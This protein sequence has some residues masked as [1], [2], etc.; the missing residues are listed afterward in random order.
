MPGT[1]AARGPGPW[2]GLETLLAQA[3]LH[4]DSSVANAIFVRTVDSGGSIGGLSQTPG[5]VMFFAEW[6][7][8]DDDVPAHVVGHE[9][10][11]NL[12][13]GHE[14]YG[15]TQDPAN[16]MYGDPPMTIDDIY[17]DGAQ[18]SHLSEE[19]IERVF[20]SPLVVPLDEG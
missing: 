13:L 20:E 10:G 2:P 6:V 5:T 18:M 14:D 1:L 3:P 9:P 4:G 11:H 19:Q 12:G 16:L 7:F 15:A 8:I 17:P